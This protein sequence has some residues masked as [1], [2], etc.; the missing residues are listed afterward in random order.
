MAMG[1]ISD[2][3][4]IAV[5]GLQTAQSLV[6]VTSDNISN[7][8]TPGYA[9]KV[10]TQAEVVAA[11]AGL[12]V[13]IASITRAADQ[14]L[15]QA[16]LS[17]SSSSSQAGVTSNFLDQA[18]SLFGDP[19]SSTSFFSGL[20]SVYSAFAAAS[21]T[22][23]SNLARSDAVNSVNTFLSSASS[24][25]DS[26]TSLQTETNQQITGDVATVNGIL[27]QLS[28][29][30]GDISRITVS[31][32][33]A[34]GSQ[35]TQAQLLNQLATMMQVQVQPT[36][37]GGVTV[38]SS[39]G[40]A[41]VGDQGA[42]TLAYSTSGASG[43]LTATPP[44]GS[45]HQL[46]VGSGAIAGL[47]QMGQV[48]LPQLST[49]LSEFVSGA[50]DQ[51]NAAHNASS[52]VPA[53]ATLTG[54]DVGMALDTAVSG[55]SGATTIAITN[56]AGVMQQRVD[57]S[58][59]GAAGGTMSVNGAAPTAF[60]TANFLTSLNTALGGSGTATFSNGVLS[61]AAGGGNGVAIADNPTTPSQ[62]I[63]GE[64]FSQFFGLNN[65]VQS[66][67]TTNYNTG[68]TAASPNTFAAGGVLNLEIS[69]ATG[70]AIRQASLTVPSGGTV[71][72]VIAALNGSMGAY[73]SF[74]LDSKGQLSFTAAA[75]SGVSISVISDNTANSIGQVSLSQTFGIG[76]TSRSARAGSF[77]VRSDI[78]A[79][80]SKLAMA[81]LDLT[82]TVGGSS[83]LGTGDGRGGQAM[84]QSGSQTTS[85]SAAGDMAAIQASVSGYAAELSGLIGT[86]AANAANA[87][88]SAAAISTQADAQR[89]TVEGVNLDQELVNLTIYQQSYNAC[90]RLVQASSDMF[91]TLLQMH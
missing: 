56:P 63:N 49:Q 87:Q 47:I 13:K 50:V 5:S 90:S 46:R 8:N 42:A 74:A 53:P 43:V 91:N 27:S 64:G 58:F 62:S 10:A 84:A 65:L 3:L 39:D 17:A 78:A 81:E 36:A 35:N 14:Y 9:R 67:T 16:S 69:D 7:V 41:L 1:S 22:P 12:G 2:V 51:I 88:K 71:G 20:D 52:A 34:S 76:S 38:R 45:P 19:S 24:L 86:K 4:N 31:G 83:A 55:F 29:I 33:D 54:G 37:T 72:G 57:I 66:T 11:G 6:T 32:G 26:L 44:R 59:S 21:A 82:Q 28:Q 89:S 30:N 25:S 15:Q 68:L 60:T 18:Q 79:D 23:S 61:I 40:T 75:N 70:A 77:S 48:E 85:F 73:G 80:P